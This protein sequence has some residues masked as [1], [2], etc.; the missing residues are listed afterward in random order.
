M[1]EKSASFVYFN[2]IINHDINLFTNDN[3]I[4]KI[5]KS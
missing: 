3:E 1:T 4:N 5:M 2:V